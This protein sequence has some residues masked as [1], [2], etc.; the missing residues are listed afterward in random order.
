VNWFRRKPAPPSAAERLRGQWQCAGC[1]VVHEGLLDLA[2]FAPDP[3]PGEAR[4][5]PNAEL[6]LDGD[7]L[8]EDFC[9]MGGR[10]F[11]VRGVLEIPVHG[12][13]EKFGFGGWSTLSRDNFDKYLAGF[14]DGAFA[15][16][17]PWSGWLCNQL[18]DYIGAQPEALWVY[19]QRQRQRPTLRIQ[20]PDHPLA[21]DQEEG[22][23]PERLLEIFDRYG[24]AAAP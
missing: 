9:V 18:A 23:T 2:A 8:S 13:A 3:W 11:F 19:P 6:R 10:Y 1:D 24:H 15:E 16:W 21:I 22:I 20:N 7:F 4:R 17:G 12:F 5:E 14:D